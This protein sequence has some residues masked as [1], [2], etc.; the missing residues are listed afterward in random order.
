MKNP[1]PTG[2]ASRPPPQAGEV[3]KSSKRLGVTLDHRLEL[4]GGVVAEIAGISDGVEDIN[5]LAAKQRQQ[6]VLEAANLADRNAVEI[7]VDAGID[8]HDLFLHFQRR[9]L[10]LL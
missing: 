4:G 10:R 5:V 3:K 6:T 1:R 9:E 8:H 2:F 7:A